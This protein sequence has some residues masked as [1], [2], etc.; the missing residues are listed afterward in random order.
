MQLS[1]KVPTSSSFAP[2]G[3]IGVGY[4]SGGI[5]IHSAF[6]AFA[7]GSLESLMQTDFEIVMSFLIYQDAVNLRNTCW[8]LH[9]FTKPYRYEWRLYPMRRYIIYMYIY[10]SIKCVI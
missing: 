6:K 9:N 3:K 7:L 10:K 5:M 4:K 8:F 1:Q 2:D